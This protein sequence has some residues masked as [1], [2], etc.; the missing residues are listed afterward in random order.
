MHGTLFFYARIFLFKS[1]L[2]KLNFYEQKRRGVFSTL[3]K[4]DDGDF[5]EN[6]KWLKTRSTEF[7][8]F[9]SSYESN[10]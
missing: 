3:S 4:I 8:K 2:F 6:S 10:D 7:E 1:K 5:C 9:L